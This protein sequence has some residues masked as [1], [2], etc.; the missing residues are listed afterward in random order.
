MGRYEVSSVGLPVGDEEIRSVEFFDEHGTSESICSLLRLAG[1]ET[2]NYLV[3]GPF[4]YHPDD[5]TQ[6]DHAQIAEYRHSSGR[7][8]PPLYR[9][10]IVIEAEP[11]TDA[12]T[13]AEWLAHRDKEPFGRNDGY[14]DE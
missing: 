2:T 14:D 5:M 3:T 9:I 12:E 6:R 8:Y 13:E 10:K 4:R 11:L 7:Q 1:A